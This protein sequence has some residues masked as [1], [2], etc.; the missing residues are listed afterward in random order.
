MRFPLIP[1]AVV[2]VLAGAVIPVFAS[3]PSVNTSTELTRGQ[4]QFI[5]ELDA[6]GTKMLSFA[7]TTPALP[8]IKTTLLACGNTSTTGHAGCCWATEGL[9]Y[10]SV[11]RD[12]VD[13]SADGTHEKAGWGTLLFLWVEEVDQIPV[14]INDAVNLPR[15]PGSGF[16]SSICGGSSV[17]G[18]VVAV[19][20]ELVSPLNDEFGLSHKG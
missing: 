12:C 11:V 16:S 18:L 4:G 8:F 3:T 1:V 14:P 7:Q 2:G 19:V 10:A 15:V 17:L 13:P 5:A 20:P 9:Q 6:Y